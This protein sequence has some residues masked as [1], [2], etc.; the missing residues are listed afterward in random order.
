MK[1]CTRFVLEHVVKNVHQKDFCI[2]KDWTKNIGSNL[3]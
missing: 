3:G 1:L 2:D